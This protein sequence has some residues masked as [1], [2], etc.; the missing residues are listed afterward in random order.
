VVGNAR[1]GHAKPGTVQQL[2]AGSQVVVKVRT[3]AQG[4]VTHVKIKIK[5]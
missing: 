5:G 4:N 3:D 2:V 1:A